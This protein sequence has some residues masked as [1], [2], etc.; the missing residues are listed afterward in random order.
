MLVEGPLDWLCVAQA[1]SDLC[2]VGRVGTSGARRV[3]WLTRLALASAVLVA[4]DADAPGDTA[5]KYW[6]DAL[7]NARRWRPYYADPAQMAQDGAG[8]RAWAAAGL[9]LDSNP[10]VTMTAPNAYGLA[11]LTRADGSQEWKKVA[12]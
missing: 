2:G 5:S 3:R 4:L 6:L 10:V 12:R 8:V 7:P 9:N 1:A 11:L